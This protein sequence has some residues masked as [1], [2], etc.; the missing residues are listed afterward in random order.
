MRP[1]IYLTFDCEDFINDRSTFALHRILQLLQKYD[2]KGLFFITGHMAEK[3]S[4][5]HDILD[6]LKVHEIG[7][8]SSAHTVRPTIIEYTDVRDY[9]LARQI[10]LKRETSH[11]NPMTGACEGE[12]GIV[13]LRRL[14]PEKRVISFRAPGFSWSPPHLEA[15]R[16]LGIEFDFS[17]N[18]TSTSVSYRSI[19]FYPYPNLID[20]I[21][22]SEYREV[23]KSLAQSRLV[24]LDFHPSYFVNLNY[25]DS[26]YF[27]CNPESLYP[28][29]A[30][31][32]K[33]TAVLLRKFERL[34]MFFSLLQK[35]GAIMLTPPLKKTEGKQIF[36]KES[37]LKSYL[38][39][40]HWTKNYFGFKPMFQWDHFKKFFELT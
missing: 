10:S 12:G 8:H 5:F 39:S 3:L 1:A 28:V 7:Y 4:H 35:S 9:A 36:T 6:M 33:E 31:E 20:V 32:W 37:V 11:I 38:A 26:I 40:I 34:L 15:L 24:V 23:A 21:N 29:K 17:T 25:W 27:T 30:R 19:T 13:L 14:F 16:D 2:I 22:P 18:L